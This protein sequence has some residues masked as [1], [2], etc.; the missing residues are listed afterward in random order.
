ME[1]AQ[2]WMTLAA[3]GGLLALAWAAPLAASWIALGGIA[4]SV[5]DVWRHF[6]PAVR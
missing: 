5:G 3:A 6:R 2:S 4:V 1:T